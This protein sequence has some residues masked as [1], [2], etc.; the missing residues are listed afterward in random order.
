MWVGFRHPGRDQPC[1][2]RHLQDQAEAALVD[3]GDLGQP[4]H[5]AHAQPAAAKLGNR[6]GAEGFEHQLDLTQ[7]IDHRSGG[8]RVD[9]GDGRGRYRR[10][11]WCQLHRSGQLAAHHLT[12]QPRQ[13]HGFGVHLTQQACGQQPL[14]RPVR[15]GARRGVA[16]AAHRRALAAAS[17]AARAA[18]RRARPVWRR[19]PSARCPRR[20][21]DPDTRAGRPRLRLPRARVASPHTSARSRRSSTAAVTVS[22]LGP[23]ADQRQQL[24]QRDRSGVRVQ[25]EQRVEHRQPQEVE[26]I[27]GRL[28]RLTGLR[29]G[30]QRRDTC[31]AAVASGRAAAPAAGSAA[32]RQARP[33][34]RPAGRPE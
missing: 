26:P 7:Q 13:N 25:D 17:A 5:V 34:R 23:L 6:C 12:D 29:A 1:G 9:I 33:A 11:G 27:G 21:P 32:R 24:G 28:D 15:R 4:L 3:T 2:R 19:C 10:I 31:P 16:G 8:Y 30:R 18:A 20:W 22:S 14:H